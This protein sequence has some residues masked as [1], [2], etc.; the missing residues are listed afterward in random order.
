MLQ[1]LDIFAKPQDDFRLKTFV[2]G[3]CKFLNNISHNILYYR[4]FRLH[5]A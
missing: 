3:I 5:V 1:Q 2:G 4:D